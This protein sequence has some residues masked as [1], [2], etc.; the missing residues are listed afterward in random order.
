MKLMP[1]RSSSLSKVKRVTAVNTSV[2][3]SPSNSPVTAIASSFSG[4]PC[5]STT[6]RM[7]PSS[8]SEKYS[9]APKRSAIWLNA[10]EAT[11]ITRV[12]IV[13]ATNEPIAAM[14]RAAPALPR[15]AIW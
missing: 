12:A 7:M 9:G 8:V 6:T 14:E 3:T 15:R 2:P 1:P 5:D 10:G 4:A 13:P 11:A